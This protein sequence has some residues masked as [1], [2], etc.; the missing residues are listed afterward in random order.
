[1]ESLKETS[2]E[3][4]IQFKSKIILML[5]FFRVHLVRQGNQ[6]RPELQEV[7]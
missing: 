1:M 3:T 2:R 7:L 6:G 5:F 4:R